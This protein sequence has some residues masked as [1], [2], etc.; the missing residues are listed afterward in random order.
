MFSTDRLHYATPL[1]RRLE[2]PAFLR[3][4]A[5]GTREQR[6]AGRRR[7]RSPS[8]F[9]RTGDHMGEKGKRVH[10]ATDDGQTSGPMRGALGSETTST[11]WRGRGEATTSGV[12]TVRP[13]NS[14]GCQGARMHGS[15]VARQWLATVPSMALAQ[16][17]VCRSSRVGKVRIHLRHNRLKS[18]CRYL[19]ISNIISE[20]G[21]KTKNEQGVNLIKALISWLKPKNTVC[22]SP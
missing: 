14:D 8:C 20:G 13:A 10:A 11:S 3:R 12:S 7:E 2:K 15:P 1:S 6:G 17:K 9:F 16:W 18:Y 4:R 21:S 5:A 19:S 22:Y